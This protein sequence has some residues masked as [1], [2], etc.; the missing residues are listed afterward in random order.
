MFGRNITWWGCDRCR[1][2]PTCE[3][4][5]GSC[6]RPKTK[7]CWKM[8][9]TAA[10]SV[11]MLWDALLSCRLCQDGIIAISGGNGA[12]GLV[13]GLWILRTAR[14]PGAFFGAA[15]SSTIFGSEAQKQGGKKFS[16]KF[17][18]RP[19]Q[20]LNF[21]TLGCVTRS[22]AWRSMKIS[23]QNMPNWKDSRIFLRNW[24]FP[25]QWCVFRQEVESLAESLG[26]HVEQAKCD[27]SKQVPHQN[28]EIWRWMRSCFFFRSQWIASWRA[29][30]PIW[31]E[32]FKVQVLCAKD[33]ILRNKNHTP[34]MYSY[35]IRIHISYNIII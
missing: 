28:V 35:Y 25:L 26:I 3:T 20:A 32:M 24:E 31:Q 6:Q 22:S 17:L 12:L 4:Q 10:K 21:F 7:M 5:N 34:V 2:S 9:M 29:S 19:S 27:V 11:E 23:E 33:I 8:R 16:I 13:M 18:S 14:R 30:R 1:A 15:F